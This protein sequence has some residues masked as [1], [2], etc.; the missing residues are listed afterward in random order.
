MPRT[1]S[2]QPDD[3]PGSVQWAL[4]HFVVAAAALDVTLGQRLDL[5]P[6]EFQAMKHVMT[7]KDPLGPVELGTLVGLTSGSATTLV[8]R[9]ERAGHLARHR[10]SRDRR[11]LTLEPTPEVLSSTRQEMRPLEA[12]LEELLSTYS[13]EDRRVVATFLRD[14]TDVYRR[15]TSEAR[16]PAAADE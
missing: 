14:A 1:R 3:S 13:E 15:F 8:D 7:T 6:S 9:L 16:L 2:P 12:A 4:H 10:D 5:S 11:R